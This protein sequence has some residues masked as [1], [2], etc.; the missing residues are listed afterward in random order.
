MGK[1]KFLLPLFVVGVLGIGYVG[2]IISHGEIADAPSFASLQKVESQ[3]RQRG[4]GPVILADTSEGKA[5]GIRTGS[6]ANPYQWLLLNK[7]TSD[8]GIFAVPPDGSVAATC[9]EIFAAIA[10]VERARKVDEYL[11]R[12]CKR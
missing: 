10:T 7:L 3:Y 2:Y 5:L 9:T 8:G 1:L 4:I 12:V 11:R 6:P